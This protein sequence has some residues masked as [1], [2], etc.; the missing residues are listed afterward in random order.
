MS[1]T[2]ISRSI[3]RMTFLVTCLAGT[4]SAARLRAVP[5]GTLTLDGKPWTGIGVNCFDAFLRTLRDSNNTSYERAFHTLDSL[6]IPFARLAFSGFYAK[7]MGLYTTN[8][9][10]YFRRLDQVVASARSH[11]IGLVP[12]LLWNQKLASEMTSQPVDSF[13]DTASATG[14][15]ARQYTREV[16][17]RYRGE[18]TIWAWE[19][20]N[21]YYPFGDLPGT[22]VYHT[23]TTTKAIRD[24]FLSIATLIRSLDPERLITSGNQVPTRNQYHRF[25]FRSDSVKYW[26]Y[27]ATDSLSEHL[28]VLAMLHPDPIDLISS[29]VYPFGNSGGY[30]ADRRPPAD[31][32]AYIRSLREIGAAL[33]KPVF[34]GEF[35]VNDQSPDATGKPMD[36]ASQA[37]EFTAMLEA[38]TQS[39]L[40]MSAVW[41]FDFAS[42]DP[43]GQASTANTPFWSITLSN[44][45]AY[46]LERLAEANHRLSSSTPLQRIPPP[47][48]QVN[49]LADGRIRMRSPGGTEQFLSI[50]LRNVSGRL[51]E[52]RSGRIGKAEWTFDGTNLPSLVLVRVRGEN[53]SRIFRI[54]PTPTRRGL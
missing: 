23:P 48:W 36:S 19:I 8:K 46:Q 35:G 18:S 50:E 27:G 53:S 24:H 10:A 21:E 14:R 47:D 2:S 44:K 42:F 38:I 1:A 17:E 34:L 45:R 39:G 37:K 33:G 16:V 29:H 54:L 51:L 43:P 11:H 9:D 32:I 40:P 28:K 41:V 3:L 6:G 49:A 4:L 25:L 7:D 30:F 12:S 13:N 26:N 22:S 31:E 15:W 52:T 5:D 20:G